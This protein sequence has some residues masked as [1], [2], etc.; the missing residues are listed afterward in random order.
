MRRQAQVSPVALRSADTFTQSAQTIRI[1]QPPLGASSAAF[2]QR[3]AALRAGCFAAGPN[4]SRAR[5]IRSA[6]SWQGSLV[7]PGGA[8]APPEC[9]LAQLARRR[10]IPLRSND[11]SRERPS[12]S[13]I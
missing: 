8:P 2:C 12:L 1:A 6:S 11:A 4:V 9:E 5:R 7:T 3:R 13:G 10:R